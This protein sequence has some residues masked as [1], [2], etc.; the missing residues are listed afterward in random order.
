MKQASK[1]DLKIAALAWVSIAVMF[2]FIAI[3]DLAGL[4]WKKWF[5]FTLFTGC[6]FGVMLYKYEESFKKARCVLLFGALLVVHVTAWSCYLRPVSGF[7]MR[8]LFVAPF[9]GAAVAFLLVTLGGARAMREGARSK[10]R[11]K[12]EQD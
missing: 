9:E 1:Q 7:P 6:V 4:D 12:G 8:L 3:L 10:P 5:G 2:A 11:H